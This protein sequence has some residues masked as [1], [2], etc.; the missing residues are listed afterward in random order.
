MSFSSK[1]EFRDI[2]NTY[3]SCL[4]ITVNYSV[5]LEFNLDIPISGGRLGSSTG[6][7]FSNKQKQKKTTK[8]RVRFSLYFGRVAE[9]E[10]LL[11][12]DIIE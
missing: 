3:I 7:D 9:I 12:Y 4:V 11:D 6:T 8:F 5:F 10:G 2:Y 1:I